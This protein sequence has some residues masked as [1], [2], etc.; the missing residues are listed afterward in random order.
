MKVN[1]ALAIGAALISSSWGRSITASGQTQVVICM[2]RFGDSALVISQ[3]QQIASHMF[4]SIGLHLAWRE[5]NG[6]LRDARPILVTLSVNTPPELFPRA[7]A[8]SNPFEGVHVRIFYDRLSVARWLCPPA[9]LLAHVLAHEIGHILQGSDQHS[10]SGVMKSCWDP[11]DYP[12][13]AR[14]PLPFSELDIEMI[15]RGPEARINPLRELDLSSHQ[16]PGFSP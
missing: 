11:F 4:E 5:L 9:L 3:A 7:L 8:Y 15:Y 6:C 10:G 1:A 14:H 2:E 13:M 16:E 12:K